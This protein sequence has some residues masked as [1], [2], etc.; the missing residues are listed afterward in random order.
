MPHLA[1]VGA[2]HLIVQSGTSSTNSDV[3]Q[4]LVYPF[5]PSSFR[6]RG[7]RVRKNE[8]EDQ[9]SADSGVGQ[10]AIWNVGQEEIGQFVDGAV[11]PGVDVD[12]VGADVGGQDRGVIGEASGVGGRSDGELPR[13]ERAVLAEEES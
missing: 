12:P 2:S 9:S 11:G 8:L 4:W 5:S 13:I 7:P 1:L 10:L 3:S 6:K